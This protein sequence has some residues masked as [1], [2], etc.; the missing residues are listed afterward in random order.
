[1]ETIPSALEKILS[2]RGVYFHWIDEK[3]DAEKGRQIGVIAQEVEKV[4]PEAVVTDTSPQSKLEGGTK[5][6]T[7]GDLVAPIINAIQEL[8]GKVSETARLLKT[9][10]V[11]TNELCVDDICVT[12]EQFK[13]MVEAAAAQ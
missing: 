10:R 11:E 8:A 5:M 2:L 1:V 4:F 3:Q 12:R 9:E 13:A 7:Y 6:V